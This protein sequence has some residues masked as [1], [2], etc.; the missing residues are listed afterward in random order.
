MD[1]MADVEQRDKE[2][3]EETDGWLPA[4][5][6]PDES[7]AQSVRGGAPPPPGG[8]VPIPYPNVREV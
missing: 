2:P 6:E 8:P 7:E 4:D 5:L 1:E 3:P